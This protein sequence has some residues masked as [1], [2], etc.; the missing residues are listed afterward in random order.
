MLSSISLIGLAG[1]EIIISR[2]S[3]PQMDNGSVTEP[4]AT[5][6]TEN[7]ITLGK[8]AVL[9]RREFYRAILIVAYTGQWAEEKRNGEA[10]NSLEA[11][12]NYILESVDFSDSAKSALKR[13]AFNVSRLATDPELTS[14]A[15]NSICQALESG[16]G[17]FNLQVASPVIGNLILRGKTEEAAEVIARASNLKQDDFRAYVQGVRRE[18]ELP[19]RA[20]TPPLFTFNVVS[21]EGKADDNRVTIQWTGSQKELTR[22]IELL[23]RVGIGVDNAL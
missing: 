11:W 19:S 17:A 20:V 18:H 7:I 22:L 23:A 15:K 1:N 21:E 6:L 4:S 13:M 12:L 8:T 16:I 2:D 9:T 3:R 10:F 5:P 14:T